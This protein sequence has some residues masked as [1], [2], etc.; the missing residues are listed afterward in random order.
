MNTNSPA[1]DRRAFLKGSGYL[2]LSF[3]LPA[4]VLAQTAPA[5]RPKLPGD[6]DSNRMLNAWIRINAD[7][8]VTLQVGKVELGQGVL[9]AMAQV[10]AEQLDIDM[11]QIKIISGD[12]FVVPNEGTTSG[13][14]SMPNGATA[15]EQAAAEVRDILLDLAAPKLGQPVER[16]TVANG[17]ITAPNGTRVSYGEL[18][19]GQE[20]A[21]EATGQA[22]L[23]PADAGPLCRQIGAAPRYPR[24]DDRRG[25]LRAGI[26]ACKAWSMAT[27][28]VR[29]PMLRSWSRLISPRQRRCPACSRSCATA[30]SSA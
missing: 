30:A 16:L 26:P 23:K 29:R 2:V 27:S 24:Q 8:T 15:V 13:S 20:L 12:T 25:D 4:A 1:L 14:L 22:K 6:L 11:A 17:V 18:I 9:T 7:N 5:A 28:S 21:R 10:C 3:S 19:T